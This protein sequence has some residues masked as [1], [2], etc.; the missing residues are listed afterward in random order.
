MP[1]ELVGI[2]YLVVLFFGG[3]SDEMHAGCGTAIH[4]LVDNGDI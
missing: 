4:V 3:S 2:R 1:F